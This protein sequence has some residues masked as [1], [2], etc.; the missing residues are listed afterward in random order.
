MREL[1]I[2]ADE[3]DL[4]NPCT[5]VHE[6]CGNEWFGTDVRDYFTDPVYQGAHSLNEAIE[7][8][9]H[10]HEIRTAIPG[11]FD[12][13]LE[14]EQRH[15]GRIELWSS[16]LIGGIEFQYGF[17]LAADSVHV[18]D[19]LRVA[20]EIDS[21]KRV[22]ISFIDQDG[23]I[24]PFSPYYDFDAQKLERACLR[25]FPNGKITCLVKEIRRSSGTCAPHDPEC[26]WTVT[27][28]ISEMFIEESLTC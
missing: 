11:D 26:T 25:A 24:L 6:P 9:G 22:D 23:T 20:Y 18:G 12:A 27:D 2:I 1:S 3:V 28:F 14:N 19:K 15:L 10:L 4:I 5:D 16:S 21:L 7:I 13:T 8:R 17:A